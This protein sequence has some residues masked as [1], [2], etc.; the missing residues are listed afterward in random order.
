MAETNFG[1]MELLQKLLKERG[2]GVSKEEQGVLGQ[3]EG[4]PIRSGKGSGY[5]SWLDE[6]RFDRSGLGSV[7]NTEMQLLDPLANTTA[8]N[9]ATTDSLA[10]MRAIVE[11]GAIQ[12]GGRPQLPKGAIQQG[13]REYDFMVDGNSEGY[14]F[15]GDGVT[16]QAKAR[17]RQ[18]QGIQANLGGGMDQVSD[19]DV[20]FAQALSGLTPREQAEI[21]SATQGYN[22]EQVDNF[23]RQYLRG[24]VSPYELEVQSN[25]GF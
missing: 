25:L 22:D 3:Y 17:M 14:S 23:K 2:T 7:S 11:G 12:Q 20:S 10:N 8:Y 1:I 18:Q 16:E 13:G 5:Q 19:L 6:N 24:K 21:I 9:N 15:T 4:T